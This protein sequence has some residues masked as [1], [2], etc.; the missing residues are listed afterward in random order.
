MTRPAA[1]YPQIGSSGRGVYD[2]TRLH[3][4][5]HC[6]K[7]CARCPLFRSYSR[8]VTNQLPGQAQ[9][10]SLRNDIPN[11]ASAPVDWLEQSLRATQLGASPAVGFRVKPDR[12]RV[13]TDLAPDNERRRF[14]ARPV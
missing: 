5:T 1:S 6:P 9:T 8:Q 4:P 7:T 12:R 3:S 14:L 10:P 2:F 11:G 13:A